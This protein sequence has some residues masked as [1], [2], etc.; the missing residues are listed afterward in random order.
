L[1]TDSLAHGG[2]GDLPH[3]E[4]LSFSRNELT[5]LPDTLSNLVELNTFNVSHNRIS[6]LPFALGKL[7][8][9]TKFVF[10][11]NPLLEP[12]LEVVA[13]GSD[14]LLNYLDCCCKAREDG[15]FQVSSIN[16]YE[17][18]REICRIT[19]M[20]CVTVCLNVP[21]SGVEGCLLVV[22]CACAF[23]RQLTCRVG[24]ADET[25]PLG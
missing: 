9:L 7:M 21:T 14:Y 16:L 4:Q 22:Y 10:N 20:V 15:V 23:V 17:V 3:L 1:Q 6:A 5:A 8:D 11:E 2:A 12:P 24:L 25:Q 13:K 19:N 18:P